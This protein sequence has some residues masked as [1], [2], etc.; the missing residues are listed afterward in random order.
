MRFR[1]AKLCLCLAA[2]LAGCSSG[3]KQ[4][5]SADSSAPTVAVA[6]VQ[7]RDLSRELAIAAEFQPFQ[8]IDVHAKVSGYVKAMHVDV[9]DRVKAGQLLATLEIPE[10]ADEVQQAEAAVRQSEEN[11]KRAQDELEQSQSAHEVAH[12]AY[13]RLAEVMKTQPDLVAQQDVDDARGRD[14]VTQAQVAGAGDALSAARQQLEMAKANQE[15]IRTLYS[16][17]RISAPFN[18]VVTK[19][20]ADNGALIQAG[21][22]SQTQTMPLVRL[23]QNDLLRLVIPV[24]ES[25]VPTIRLGSPVQV[26]VAALRK[27]FTGTVARFADQVDKATRTMHTEVDVPNPQLELVPGMYAEVSVVLEQKHNVLVAPVQALDHREDEVTV[28]VVNAGNEIEERAVKIGIETPDQVEIL[29]GLHENDLVVVGS[30][31]QLRPGTRVSP[32]I[33][34]SV[35]TSGGQ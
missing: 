22:A 7:R 10:L 23:S 5:S 29:S 15:R 1:G 2:T 32:K 3:P 27:A 20:Y 31:G 19:R 28:F 9:G 13:S 30:R 17:A 34:D 21:T 35:E 8:E 6:R 18:G 14:R 25:A 33:V 16:Y 4:H 26:R 12:V 24:P 11:I